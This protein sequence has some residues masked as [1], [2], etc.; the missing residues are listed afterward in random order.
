MVLPERKTAYRGYS[1]RQPPVALQQLQDLYLATTTTPGEKP[2]ADQLQLGEL[3]FNAADR[4]G[5]LG[6]GGGA[7]Y[8]FPLGGAP[9]AGGTVTHGP[10]APA[11]P[12]RG[13][14]WVDTAQ[15]PP[16]LKLWGGAGWVVLAKPD[17]VTVI[18]NPATGVLQVN[19]LDMGQF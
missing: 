10:V 17:G 12:A 16:E 13:D 5:F 6:I 2:A 18:A 11:T 8:E 9:A 3:A 4:L 14:I 19:E 7:Y 15:T 1:P